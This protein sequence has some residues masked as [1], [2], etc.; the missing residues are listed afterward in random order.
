METQKCEKNVPLRLQLR[1]RSRLQQGAHSK[2]SVH[3]PVSLVLKTPKVS[4]EFYSPSIYLF[5]NMEQEQSCLFCLEIFLDTVDLLSCRSPPP[6]LPDFAF[7]VA[8]FPPLLVTAPDLASHPHAATWASK[9]PGRTRRRLRCT[10]QSGQ[11]AMFEAEPAALAGVLHAQP[12]QV[13]CLAPASDEHSSPGA[14]SQSKRRLLGSGAVPT[15]AFRPPS[16]GGWQRLAGRGSASWGCEECAVALKDGAGRTVAVALLVMSLTAVNKALKAVVLGAPDPLANTT[17]G[18]KATTAVLKDDDVE[19]V[20]WAPAGSPKDVPAVRADPRQGAAMPIEP[21]IAPPPPPLAVEIPASS[22]DNAGA[23]G[24]HSGHHHQN[25]GTPWSQS[26]APTVGSG[27]L[28]LGEGPLFSVGNVTRASVVGLENARGGYSTLA[29]DGSPGGFQVAGDGGNDLA[30]EQDATTPVDSVTPG[31]TYSSNGSPAFFAVPPE[32]ERAVASLDMDESLAST[33]DG[34]WMLGAASSHAPASEESQRSPPEAAHWLPVGSGS[35]PGVRHSLA[36]ADTAVFVAARRS[37]SGTAGG[38]AVSSV[39]TRPLNC[40]TAAA[41]ASRTTAPVPAAA[42][43]AAPTTTP[44]PSAAPAAVASLPPATSALGADAIAVAADGAAAPPPFWH[45]EAYSFQPKP[46]FYTPRWV[47]PP[48]SSARPNV[49]PCRSTNNNSTGPA[50]PINRPEAGARSEGTIRGPSGA[51]DVNT[52]EKTLAR[53]EARLNALPPAN[54]ASNSDYA[55]DTGIASLVNASGA[56][57]NGGLLRQVLGEMAHLRSKNNNTANAN[58]ATATSSN[59]PFS[60]SAPG[61]TGSGGNSSRNNTG[62]ASVLGQLFVE[63]AHLQQTVTAEKQHQLRLSRA[64]GAVPMMSNPRD[65]EVAVR[66]KND[67]RTAEVDARKTSFDSSESGSTSVLRVR[68]RPGNSPAWKKRYQKQD[69]IGSS[70][71][72]KTTHRQGNRAPNVNGSKPT[73]EPEDVPPPPLHS[74][75]AGERLEAWFAEHADEAGTVAGTALVHELTSQE[76]GHSS[77]EDFKHQQSVLLGWVRDGEDDLG[78]R[79]VGGADGEV[80]VSY[81]RAMGLLSRVAAGQDGEGELAFKS[82]FV[83]SPGL[84]NS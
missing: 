43:A 50:P 2:Q 76:Y 16:A 65:D 3:S 7:V 82:E 29:R 17:K 83:P 81:A 12:M 57:D 51:L 31:L 55:A 44:T 77:G 35:E 20:K 1:N 34:S 71:T 61:D 64:S 39:S 66:A 25:H 19:E 32:A 79:D 45:E 62:R 68:R 75:G 84:R 8:D 4:H 59:H 9:N 6:A 41:E 46:L 73:A 15:Q 10:Y 13:L 47:P 60:A 69:D 18:H 49:A 56:G 28:S 63:L 53:I 67:S 37:G 26:G 30:Y 54:D 23:Q 74:P 21:P 22:V 27:T 52:L 48:Q 36:G 24:Q 42:P 58:T 38:G 70:T 78:G 11:S 72:A 33:A 40:A 80:R 5:K 14:E